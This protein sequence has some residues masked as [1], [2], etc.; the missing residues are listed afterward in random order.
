MLECKEN[1]NLKEKTEELM[2][3]GE[4][5]INAAFKVTGTSPLK[6]MLDMDEETA[7]MIAHAMSFYKDVRELTILQAAVLD[8]LMD[9]MNDLKLMNDRLLRQNESLQALLQ[10]K[11]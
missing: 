7:V 11:K 10:E 2:A 5:F 4:E 6:M 1:C 8:D 3:K 9:G